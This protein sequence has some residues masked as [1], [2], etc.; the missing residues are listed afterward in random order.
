MRPHDKTTGLATPRLDITTTN[1]RS[2][3]GTLAVQQKHVVGAR[4]DAQLRSPAIADRREADAQTSSDSVRACDKDPRAPVIAKLPLR[5][6]R[7]SRLGSKCRSNNLILCRIGTR[8]DKRHRIDRR[9]EGVRGP[10]RQRRS[11]LDARI[12]SQASTQ[13]LGVA[14]A[15]EFCRDQQ[16]DRSTGAGELESAFGERDR[17]IGQVCEPLDSIG[18]PA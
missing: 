8:R 11:A 18:S 15:G 9:A 6:D 16:G 2:S 12:L 7:G 1:D 13:W 5:Q 3:A 10:V 17:E 14:A 4:F